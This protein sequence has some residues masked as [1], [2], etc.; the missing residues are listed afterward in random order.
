M[1]TVIYKVSEDISEKIEEEPVVE[2]EPIVEE[3]PVEEE[4]EEKKDKKKTDKQ[5][6]LFSF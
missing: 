6:S 1:F 2:E 4:V 3:E 5:V